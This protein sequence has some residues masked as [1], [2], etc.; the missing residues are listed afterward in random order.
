MESVE[1]S[2]ANTHKGYKS[3]I[4]GGCMSRS[5]LEAAKTYG[6][7]MDDFLSAQPFVTFPPIRQPEPMYCHPK[8]L[9]PQGHH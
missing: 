5:G 1:F 2:S 4:D 8:L 3:M 7:M 6:W 9:R